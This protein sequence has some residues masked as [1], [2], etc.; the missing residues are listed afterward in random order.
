VPHKRSSTTGSARDPAGGKS[1]AAPSGRCRGHPANPSEARRMART[2]LAR[3]WHRGSSQ[4]HR[5]C[6]VPRG[7]GAFVRV[8]AESGTACGDATSHA[9]RRLASRRRARPGGRVSHEAPSEGSRDGSPGTELAAEPGCAL[10]AGDF[11][12]AVD[13]FA[14]R[15]GDVCMLATNC[16][17]LR[18]VQLAL[19]TSEGGTFLLGVCRSG[20]FCFCDKIDNAAVAAAVP[21]RLPAKAE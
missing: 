18:S 13:F 7:D 10:F 6:S 4:R 14:G 17:A 12:D 1:R 20:C 19:R 21:R 9:L 3:C 16:P 5:G 8:G 15:F 11:I 2:A